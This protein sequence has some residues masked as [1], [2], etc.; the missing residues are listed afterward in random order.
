M[1]RRIYE[2]SKYSILDFQK[3]VTGKQ[4]YLFS[5]VTLEFD[6]GQHRFYETSIQHISMSHQ[7]SIFSVV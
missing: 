6:K 2:I 1:L 5:A 7:W 3:N 4:D